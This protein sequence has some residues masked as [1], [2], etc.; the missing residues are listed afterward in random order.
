[1]CEVSQ[2]QE[3]SSHMYIIYIMYIYIRITTLD[4]LD[5]NFMKNSCNIDSIEH[6]QLANNKQ[7]LNLPLQPPKLLVANSVWQ[8]I[9]LALQAQIICMSMLWKN[10]LDTQG[11]ENERFKAAWWFQPLWKNIS[12]LG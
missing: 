6:I 3:R 7:R 12:Q 1:M 10:H 4:E 9:G 8:Y 2:E 5:H 11:A